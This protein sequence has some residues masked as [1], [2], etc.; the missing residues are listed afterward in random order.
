MI[1]SQV[2]D[3]KKLELLATKIRL[4]TLETIKNMGQGHLGGS[5]SIVEL[6]AVL[7]GKQMKFNPKNPQ[8]EDR[9][10][11]VLSKGHAGTGLYSALA[12][13]GYFDNE[14]LKTVNQGGTNLPSHPDRMKTPGVDVTTGSLGQGTSV[15]AGVATGLRMAQ[16]EN[17]VYLIVGDGELNEGQC[18]EAFQY[19]A[20]FKLNHCIVIIDE[21]KKQLDGTTEEI[22]NPFDIQKKMEAF[23]FK[24]LK[25]KGDDISG[26]N[27][28]INCCKEVKDQAVCIVLDSIKGQGVTYFEKM[29]ANHS[30]KFNTDEVNQAANEAIR[31]LKQIIEEMA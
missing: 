8:W 25:V 26:I 23:G 7:Y 11:L 19:I 13:V 18:W 28:A 4:T 30:V 31:E 12:N 20:H 1:N 5:F 29:K 24:T 9:D 14:L 2:D 27:Q 17:Y 21:N 16:K 10:W 22:L 3:I 15:A 6:L